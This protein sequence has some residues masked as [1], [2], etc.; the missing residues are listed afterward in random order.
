MQRLKVYAI[1]IRVEPHAIFLQ[2]FQ[3]KLRQCLQVESACSPCGRVVDVFQDGIGD[4][5]D[6]A[7]RGR[8]YHV[9]CHIYAIELAYHLVAPPVEVHIHKPRSGF[10]L[11]LQ[12]FFQ[13]CNLAY[14]V[15]HLSSPLR[16]TYFPITDENTLILPF[17]SHF[18]K[19]M[20]TK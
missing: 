12:V 18:F 3:I 14:L 10:F 5:G 1:C 20:L 15:P 4:V 9:C 11:S 16:C 7:E 13:T 6:T 17:F 2:G 8:V 19:F